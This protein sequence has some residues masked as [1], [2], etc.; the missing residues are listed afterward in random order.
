MV[1]T[2]TK[3]WN[4]LLVN[5]NKIKEDWTQGTNYSN[6]LKLFLMA[7]DADKKKKYI[8][9]IYPG[10]H[11]Q[12]EDINSHYSV[13]LKKPNAYYLQCLREFLYGKNKIIE[14]YI[15]N[16]GDSFNE[17]E[18]KN[19]LLALLKIFVSDPNSLIGILLMKIW[20]SKN[21][22]ETFLFTP[23]LSDRKIEQLINEI[24]NVISAVKR[25]KKGKYEYK[26]V[27][28]FQNN[29]IL[30]FEKQSSDKMQRAFSKN[31]RFKPSSDIL[32]NI[33]T[34]KYLLEI[35]CSNM[36]LLDTLADIIARK[37]A[38][39][40]VYY[41]KDN[42]NPINLIK[43]QTGLSTI[44]TDLEEETIGVCEIAFNRIKLSPSSPLIIP[45][46]SGRDIRK[47]LNELNRE[48][49][50]DLKNIETVDYLK[51]IYNDCDRR[52][53]FNQ[54]KDGTL[55]LKLDSRH[56]TREK[57]DRLCELFEEQFGI[58]IGKTIVETNETKILENTYNLILSSDI[59]D[60]VSE[61]VKINLADLKHKGLI[62]YSGNKIYLCQSCRKTFSEVENCPNC[63]EKLKFILSK[64]NVK[65]NTSKILNLIKTKLVSNGFN[66]KDTLIQRTYLNK[67]KNFVQIYYEKE[68]FYLYFNDGAN[69][70]HMIEYFK[71]SNV[72]IIIINNSKRKLK[73]FDKEIFPQ[74]SLA[75][76]LIMNDNQFKEYFNKILN[77]SKEK[78]ETILMQSADHSSNRLNAYL[79][80]NNN[81]YDENMLE[82]DTY[83]LMRYI[84]KTGE[85]WG[86]AV[87][88]TTVPLAYNVLKDDH[89]YQELRLIS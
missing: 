51:I 25:K 86:K 16:N 58:P 59:I 84:F 76:L 13:I 4:T 39:N 73:D 83:N 14:E 26:G 3:Y 36:L 27:Y 75:K 89:P 49:I 78:I 15:V 40:L 37:L 60:K 29:H 61:V 8:D 53:K 31:I 79:N 10:N 82:D 32:F 87:S 23:A 47:T 62:N 66:L 55:T 63:G 18:T 6:R 64:V 44:Q 65:R 20:N 7:N 88:G 67:K 80:G 21:I 30:W 35:K 42:D 77:K 46:R 68:T 50:I 41:Y 52:I 71:H 1:H 24:N 22:D 54:N 9:F 56:L 70:E 34:E 69:I 5:I 33:N 17:L 38:I 81:E 72:P 19:P 48:E 11:I 45:K 12:K 74:I 57:M 28:E 85:K 2:T 43:F